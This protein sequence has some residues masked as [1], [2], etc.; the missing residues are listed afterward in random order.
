MQMPG[1]LGS[2]ALVGLLA[3]AVMAVLMLLLLLATCLSPGQQD[4]DVE[5]N[6][7]PNVRRN[8]VWRPYPFRSRV[9]LGRFH[10]PHHPGHVS[11]MRHVG[12]SHH[13]VHHHHG[14]HHA[15]RGHH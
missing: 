1:L 8:R 11:P 5:R 3:G 14:R 7:A 12:L 15:H 10:H 9:R 4:L 6:P 2:L 13:H